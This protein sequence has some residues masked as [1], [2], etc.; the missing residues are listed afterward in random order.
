M[1]GF[2][3]ILSAFP[4]AY[5]AAC[6]YL[7]A[8]QSTRCHPI[9]LPHSSRPIRH[10][11]SEPKSLRRRLRQTR[12]GRPGTGHGTAP[13]LSG[14]AV[15]T[16][17]AR[18][19]QRIGCPAIGWRML[20]QAGSGPTADG[21]RELSRL[22]PQQPRDERGRLF[23]SWNDRRVLVFLL[24]EQ[25]PGIIAGPHKIREDRMQYFGRI[26]SIA[27]LALVTTALSGCYPPPPPPPPVAAIPPEQTTPP[28][29]P[30]ASG[31]APSPAFTPNQTLPPSPPPAYPPGAAAA[32]TRLTRYSTASQFGSTA[33]P[34][35]APSSAG[36]TTVVAPF[37]PPAP[38]KELQPPPPPSPTAIPQTG[39]WS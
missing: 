19:R 5:C 23:S 37:G 12:C 18:H 33:P 17:A 7:A 9:A 3:R 4:S 27:A 26:A 29:P 14:R 28:P 25:Q 21:S 24:Q 6:C 22:S 16:S 31:P 38:L 30:I 36:T 20:E 13:A 8:R 1:P 39:H 34:A 15:R 32:P 2:D 11:Q 10:R 35:E